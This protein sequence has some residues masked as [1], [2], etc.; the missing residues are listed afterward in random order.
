M[1]VQVLHFKTLFYVAKGACK[2]MQA[3]GNRAMLLVK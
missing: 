3:W 1:H 2:G